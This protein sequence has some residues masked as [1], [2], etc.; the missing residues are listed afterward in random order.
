MGLVVPKMIVAQILL[1]KP[2]VA[3]QNNDWVLGILN[4]IFKYLLGPVGDCLPNSRVITM[5]RL[6]QFLTAP[7]ANLG[8]RAMSDTNNKSTRISTA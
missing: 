3:G 8:S 4:I 6:P 1:L 7:L 5:G 2:F